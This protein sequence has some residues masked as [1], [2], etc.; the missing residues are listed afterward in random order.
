MAISG[1]R[2]AGDK[3]LQVQGVFL[4]RLLNALNALFYKILEDILLYAPLGGLA[5]N[6][7]A[8]FRNTK[9]AYSTA[10][11]TTSSIATRPIAIAAA[12]KAGISDNTANFAIP[13]GAI[14]NADGGALHMGVS[15]VFA[16]NIMELDRAWNDFII[17]VVIGTL[18]SIGTAGG[19]SPA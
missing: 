4:E 6:V 13:L 1:M 12:K 3:K 17:I 18:L 5:I 15:L 14:F 11:F 10:F 19:R 2:Y 7:W 8:F 16:A 9:E